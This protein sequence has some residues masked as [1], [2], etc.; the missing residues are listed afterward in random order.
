MLHEL[1][2]ELGTDAANTLM[3]GDTVHDLQMA[4]NAGV[5]AVAVSHG[6]HPRGDLVELA[7]LACVE[8]IDELTR[9]LAQN[10]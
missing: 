7:P 3:I 5:Q 1:M 6:A 2:E 4:A 8:N 9:W 10:A